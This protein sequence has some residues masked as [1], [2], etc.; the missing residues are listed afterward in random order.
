M[1]IVMPGMNGYQATRALV[2]D[3]DT[4]PHPD[5]DGH[6]QGTRDRPHLG[7]A[8]GRRRLHGEAGDAGQAGG[9]SPVH[10]GSLKGSRGGRGIA[11]SFIRDRPFD[12]LVALDRRGR[13][14]AAVPGEEA[15][16]DRE[17]VGV[18]WR[19]AGESYLVAR[20]ETREVLPY[21]SQLTRVPGAKRLGQGSRQRARRAAAGHRP[22]PVPR[23]RRHAADPQHTRAGRESPRSAGR[24]DGRR[25]A[26]LP[27][28]R[29]TANSAATRRPPSCAASVSSRARSGADPIP[30]RCSACACWSR[31][32]GSWMPQPDSPAP[33]RAACCCIGSAALLI[34]LSAALAV[35]AGGGGTGHHGRRASRSSALV[36][37][38]LL[39]LSLKSAQRRG[40][41]RSASRSRRSGART[42]AT[43]R[44]SCGCSTRSR[45]SARAT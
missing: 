3:P 25:G 44:R 9:E 14:A 10:A 39:F 45:A 28:F 19:M 37:L 20:E 2:N 18:A 30:G 5:R 8:P 7:P 13:A 41:A 12:L 40:A 43:R 38:A 11:D 42:S 22:A 31:I 35:F 17:W 1:D 6:L 15:T 16:A 26:G 36:P 21:P 33:V 29:R 24:P 32:R 23:Q 27:A 34:L 4:K